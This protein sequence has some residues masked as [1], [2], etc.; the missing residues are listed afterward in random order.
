MSGAQPWSAA[1][2]ALL[3]AG[4]ASSRID[5]NYAEAARFAVDH[6]GVEPQW[7]R[8][9]DAQAGAVTRVD[10]WLAEPLSVDRA[11]HIA[12]TY[13]P[14]LQAVLAEAAAASADATQSARLRNPVFAFERLVRT[15]H[16]EREVELGQ[17]LGISLLDFLVLPARRARADAQQRA[18]RLQLAGAL[19]TKVT[20]T[21]TAWIRAVAAANMAVQADELRAATEASA[22]LAARME[23]N[24]NFS[25]LQRA[26]V[27]ERYAL[28]T[29]DQIR[30]RAAASETREA[31][32]R[33]LG[34]DPAQA[35]RLQLPSALPALPERPRDPADMTRAAFTQDAFDARVDVR[36][37]RADLERTARDLGLTRVTSVVDGLHVAALR[38][39]ETGEPV[40]RGFEIEMSLPVFDFGDAARAGAQARYLAA[41]NRSVQIGR[42]A[43][44]ELRARYHAYR[45]AHD[46]ARHHQDEIVPLR[47]SITDEMVL[48]YNG[49]LSGVFELLADG[50]AQLAA[51]MQAQ[52]AVRDFWLADAALQAALLGVPTAA[53]AATPDAPSA[54]SASRGGH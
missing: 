1:L 25:R 37:A 10:D 3:L 14:E 34:L 50:Q 28:A 9:A 35:A 15:G 54:A 12:L 52:Q 26:R 11:L 42:A 46:L 47:Q 23:A 48:R 33:E 21:R 51:Q 22:E 5:D 30:A 20:A 27:Q 53:G 2:V 19:G 39:R 38:N 8:A 17:A 36:L 49:M 13:S 44:G 31:L 41:F 4:C 6:L 45:S 32:V 16:G 29:A 18:V 24:R 43:A 40:Q 7:Q